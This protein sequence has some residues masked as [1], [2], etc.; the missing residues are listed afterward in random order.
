MTGVQVLA[1][2]CIAAVI[3]T[4]P[5]RQKPRSRVTFQASG[6]RGRVGRN[7][8]CADDSREGKAPFDLLSGSDPLLV[9]RPVP[10]DQDAA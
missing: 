5:K 4:P 9:R 7:E 6:Q 1:S 3:L 2:V 8:L 10:Y